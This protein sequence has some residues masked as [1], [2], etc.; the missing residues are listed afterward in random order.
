MWKYLEHVNIMLNG[1]VQVIMDLPRSEVVPLILSNNPHI[2]R[3]VKSLTGHKNAKTSQYNVP[4]VTN[5]DG[6]LN[7]NVLIYVLEGIVPLIKV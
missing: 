7:S 1:V 6:E 5:Q 4:F 2:C 3:R